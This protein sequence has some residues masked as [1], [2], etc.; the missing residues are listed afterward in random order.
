[1]HINVVMIMKSKNTS[2]LDIYLDF[3][4]NI[5]YCNYHS[6]IQLNI[7]WHNLYPYECESREKT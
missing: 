2:H 5:F 1:M 3:V 4:I 7:N 6:I